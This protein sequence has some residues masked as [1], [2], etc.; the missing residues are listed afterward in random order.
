M[1]LNGILAKKVKISGDFSVYGIR[2]SFFSIHY[3][4]NTTGVVC[5][6]TT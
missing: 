6:S 3:L 2:L 1:F 5:L 4:D